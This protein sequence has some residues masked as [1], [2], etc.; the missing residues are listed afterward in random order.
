MK[1]TARGT[2]QTSEKRGASTAAV[3]S[4]NASELMSLAEI[5]ELIE[6]VAAKQ[7]TE[8]ELER[9]QFRLRLRHGGAVSTTTAAAA[10]PALPTPGAPT[11]MPEIRPIQ[12]SPVAPEV[13]AVEVPALAEESLHFVTSP[14]VGTFY[15]AASPTADP[16]VKLGEMVEEGKTLCIIEAMKLMNEIPS[17][18]RGT[19]V[20]IL[21]E[22]GQP[23]EYGQPL[24]GIRVW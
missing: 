18:A 20:K 15:R 4:V 19:L 7:F 2:K 23:V 12:A 5:K 9:G 21:V 8:F 11:P 10:L 14:I 3:P 6:L 1:K 16:F 17:D 22:N 13:S 24:F